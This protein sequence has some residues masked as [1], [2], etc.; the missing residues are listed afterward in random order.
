VKF[1]LKDTYHGEP[2]VA[3][4]AWLNDGPVRLDAKKPT[5]ETD[6]P[7]QIAVLDACVYVDRVKAP[8][9]KKAEKAPEP[10]PSEASV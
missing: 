7:A 10:A 9:K 5:I 2:V 3:F 8:P 1:R 4:E 6:D